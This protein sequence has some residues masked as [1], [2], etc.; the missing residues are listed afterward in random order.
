MYSAATVCMWIFKVKH[1]CQ[2]YTNKDNSTNKQ[3]KKY[4]KIRPDV[5]SVIAAPSYA[6][7]YLRICCNTIQLRG[8]STLNYAA[9]HFRL[10]SS[11]LATVWG[12]KQRCSRSFMG[13]S[14]LK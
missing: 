8:P 12:L 13:E 14:W 4:F 2:S 11:Q 9:M 1:Q 5:T 7:G 3:Y 10:L 6:D